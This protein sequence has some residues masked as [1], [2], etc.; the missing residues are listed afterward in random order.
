MK[1]LLS[2]KPEYAEKIFNGDKKYEYRRVIFKRT[3][4]EKVIVYA[5][6]P[7][8]GIIGEFEIEKII[9]EDIQKLWTETRKESGISEE[10]FYKYFEGKNSGYAI[11]IKSPLRY[12]RMLDIKSKYGVKPPQ[13]FVYVN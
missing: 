10:Y 8:S 2:I 9:N 4:I 5:S 11:E 12:Q 3:D 6:A 7:I 13:S 1:V